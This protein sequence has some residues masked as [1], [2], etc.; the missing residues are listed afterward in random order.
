MA[1]DDYYEELTSDEAD[2]LL[3]LHDV[4]K[5]LV[6]D[7]Y[8]ITL[9]RLAYEL[10][11]KTQELSDYLPIIITMLNKVEEEYAEIR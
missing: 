11:V 8:P 9:V 3:D 5:R 10:G 2:F 4:I 6:R 7:S 1:F